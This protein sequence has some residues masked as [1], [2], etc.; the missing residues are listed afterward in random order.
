MVMTPEAKSFLSKTIRSLRSKL[1]DDFRSSS[2]ST[3]KFAIS[4]V[5]DAKLNDALAARRRRIEAWLQE[6]VRAETGKGTKRTAEDFR[7]ELENRL[8]TPC[9]TGC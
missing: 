6:Q 4:N 1:L 5:K 8:P 9:L 7:R 2:D 3:Y